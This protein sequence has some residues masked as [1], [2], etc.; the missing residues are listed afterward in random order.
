MTETNIDSENFIMDLNGRGRVYIPT[1]SQE[2]YTIN[3]YYNFFL[4]PTPVG[5]IVR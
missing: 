4:F 1:R 3:W 5:A 2:K